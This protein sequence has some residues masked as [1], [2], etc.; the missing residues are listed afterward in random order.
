LGPYAA[1][2]DLDKVYIWSFAPLVSM[3][4]AAA[5]PAGP[6]VIITQAEPSW[7]S[8]DDYRQRVLTISLRVVNVGDAPAMTTQMASCQTAPSL[9]MASSLPSLSGLMSGESAISTLR[10]RVP[11]GLSRFMLMPDLVYSDGIDIFHTYEMD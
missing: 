6:E 4:A 1:N 9:V 10:Y 7:M 11:A 8:L 3:T 2:K 5:T